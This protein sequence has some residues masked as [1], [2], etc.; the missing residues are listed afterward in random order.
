M[1]IAIVVP[2]ARLLEILD[3][4]EVCEVREKTQK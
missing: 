3:Y 1:G 2:V 4:P